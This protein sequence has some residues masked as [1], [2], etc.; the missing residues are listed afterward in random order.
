MSSDRRLR[1]LAPPANLAS[2]AYCQSAAILPAADGAELMQDFNAAGN[3]ED[4]EES[5]APLAA[6]AEAQASASAPPPTSARL[7]RRSS[8]EPSPLS[9]LPSGS[10]LA[11]VGEEEALAARS[12][13]TLAGNGA[14]D[15]LYCRLVLGRQRHTSFIKRAHQDGTVHW[16]Q[17]GLACLHAWE[18][19]DAGLPRKVLNR[20]LARP[21]VPG[22]EPSHSAGPPLLSL[23][24]LV[25]L[26]TFVFAVP[27]PLRDR[28][29]RVELYRTP[30]SSQKGRLV[31]VAHVSARFRAAARQPALCGALAQPLCCAADRALARPLCRC[32]C[33]TCCL[34][35]WRSSP[36]RPA[37]ALRS[38]RA[39]P[40]TC[41]RGG[42]TSRPPWSTPTCAG[43]P[44]RRPLCRGARNRLQPTRPLQQRRRLGQQ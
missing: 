43:R 15:R 16:Q 17:V 41:R 31:S 36:R 39:W 12:A 40:G 22:F 2:S 10:P 5:V 35:A 4:D 14:G 18:S 8:S 37:A 7:R 19:V 30:S 9:G 38:W 25:P 28:Q 11:T 23:P 32:G 20:R 6:E 26:Q 44:T 29:L 33:T 13:S 3:S 21:C 42:C 1:D 24:R 27:L 34:P